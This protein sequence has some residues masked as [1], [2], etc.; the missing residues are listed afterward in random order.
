MAKHFTRIK[1]K[2]AR[3]LVTH[4]IVYASRKYPHARR[5]E[6]KVDLRRGAEIDPTYT[7][8]L[9]AIRTPLALG[10]IRIIRV[11]QC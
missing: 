10:E 5:Q 7:V 8:G 6:L 1:S 11:E 9:V 4:R 3:G 2:T